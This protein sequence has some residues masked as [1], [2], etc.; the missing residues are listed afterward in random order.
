MVLVGRDC[1]YGNVDLRR[2]LSNFNILEKTILLGER[3]DIADIL[4][5]LDVLVIGS[6]FGEALPIVAIEASA[7]GLPVV[8]TDVGDIR[9]F[10]LSSDDIIPKGDV[11]G[12]AAA[13]TRAMQY[14]SDRGR[15][16]PSTDP[17]NRLLMKYR[18]DFMATK[19]L[20]LYKKVNSKI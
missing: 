13:L 14:R 15:T 8:T 1:T 19:Y 2:L 18:V 6:S 16:D 17:R 12:M 10:V 5:A 7:N 11:A 9:D 20:N 4:S 3:S